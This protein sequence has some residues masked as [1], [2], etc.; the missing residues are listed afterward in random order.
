MAIRR[1]VNW[2]QRISFRV[3]DE[4]DGS[5]T[6]QQFGDKAEIGDRPVRRSYKAGI[7]SRVGFFRRGSTIASF[8]ERIRMFFI[9]DRC[10]LSLSQ[11]SDLSVLAKTG[12][13][14]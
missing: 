7:G 2:K 11:R 10:N 4:S 12:T 3:T 1:L 8:C 5:K 13:R 14:T 6:F 9:V